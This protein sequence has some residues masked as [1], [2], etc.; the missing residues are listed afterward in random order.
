MTDLTDQR[1]IKNIYYDNIIILFF[2]C[3]TYNPTKK[4]RNGQFA[5]TSTKSNEKEN[6]QRVGFYI[7]IIN[8]HI[9]HVLL[10]IYMQVYRIE[11]KK[12]Q[13]NRENYKRNRDKSI[14]N[15]IIMYVCMCLQYVVRNKVKITKTVEIYPNI[16]MNIPRNVF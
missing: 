1:S 10:N 7:I 16:K 8:I 11:S 3:M 15:S 4:C 14:N 9:V 13:K 2:L 6:C 5:S 12:I